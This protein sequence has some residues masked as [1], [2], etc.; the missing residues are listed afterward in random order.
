MYLK[1]QRYVFLGGL[2]ANLQSIKENKGSMGVAMVLLACLCVLMGLL[3]LP[4]L[5]ANILEPAVN[6]LLEGLS[7]ST[8]ILSMR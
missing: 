2:P 8:K 3:L 1:V 6:V 7:Y 5:R 4:G